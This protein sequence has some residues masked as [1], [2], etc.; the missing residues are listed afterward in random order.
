MGLTGPTLRPAGL[1]SH[2]SASAS[3][4]QFTTALKIA[5]TPFIQ[6]GLIQGSRIDATPYIYTALYPLSGDILETLIHISHLDQHRPGGIG[7]EL[8]NVVD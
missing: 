5:S 3:L 7:L 8:S 2:L 4:R 1:G 6:V